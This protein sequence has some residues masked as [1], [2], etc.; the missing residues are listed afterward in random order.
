MYS[1]NIDETSITETFLPA[2]II[3]TLTGLWW[4][5]IFL[6]TKNVI[7]AGLI[8]SVLLILTFIYGPIRDMITPVIWYH[9]QRFLFITESVLFA[10]STFLILKL[11]QNLEN[12]NIIFNVISM[13]LIGMSLI[14]AFSTFASGQKAGAFKNIIT[15]S[16]E[17]LQIPDNLPDVYYI[18]ADGYGRSD[19]L[20]KLYGYDNSHFIKYLE[21]K[22]FFVA[23][24]SL[25]NYTQTLLSLP[26][27]LNMSYVDGVAEQMGRYSGNAIPLMNLYKN[28][29]ILK[30]FKEIGY[31]TVAFKTGYWDTELRNSDL[32]LS[33]DQYILTDF[34]SIILDM[35]PV[36]KILSRIYMY[37]YE[38]RRQILTFI[39]NN[40][41]NLPETGKPKF[42]LA[43]I[44]A[45]HEPYVY[46]KYG[47]EFDPAIPFPTPGRTE[48]GTFKEK[49]Q[50]YSDFAEWLNGRLIEV[51]DKILMDTTKESIIILQADHGSD[52]YLLQ[53]DSS[54]VGLIEKL[55]ILNAYYFPDHYYDNLY[56][57]ISPVNS[58]RIVLNQY[59][60]AKLNLL[61]DKIYFS[62]FD[63]PYDFKDVTDEV[64][65]PLLDSNFEPAIHFLSK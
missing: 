42:V 33:P 38:A 59:F 63:T 7:K 1:F 32:F 14:T 49:N 31:T 8:A 10:L 3:L 62:R 51:L 16:T 28:S 35:T 5:I 61:E 19:V 50:K 34:E 22:G 12:I 65:R 48:Y 20:R 52:S 55:A 23:H 29:L 25:S 47:N 24:K 17:D 41:G 57:K 56:D 43:H 39:L 54:Y 53:G 21:D 6:F 45:P 2:L 60:G 58:F 13:S 30:L 9:P 26:S 18:I 64:N 40:L 27:S 46:D 4:L 44:P 11:K 15:V 37:H 36:S